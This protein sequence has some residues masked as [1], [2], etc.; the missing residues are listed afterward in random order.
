MSITIIINFLTIIL[1]FFI[2]TECLHDAEEADYELMETIIHNRLRRDSTN[3]QASF[4][5]LAIRSIIEDS[6]NES[7]VQSLD[8]E[9]Q[10]NENSGKIL[11][12][13]FK[14]E[15]EASSSKKVETLP[16]KITEQLLTSHSTSNVK[17]ETE[18]VLKTIMRDDPKSNDDHD[19]DNDSTKC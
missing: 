4:E 8:L 17:E 10:Q 7:D 9:C 1:F 11:D 5:D 13:D 18:H 3:L 14:V 16:S 2:E 6:Q 19:Y 12:Q 15:V